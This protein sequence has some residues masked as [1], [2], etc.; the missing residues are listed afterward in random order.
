ML[1]VSRAQIYRIIFTLAG[2]YNIAVGLWAAL[3]PRALFEALDLGSPSHPG[4]WAC[5]GMVIGLYGL[6]YFQVAFT[7]PE[8]RSSAP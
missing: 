1:R 3:A 8:R 7:D 6:V 2:V 4:I 5:L